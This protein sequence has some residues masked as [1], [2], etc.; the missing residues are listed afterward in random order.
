MTRYVLICFYFVLFCNVFGQ[1]NILGGKDIDIENVPWQVSIQKNSGTHF[2]GG[3]IISKEWILTAAHCLTQIRNP[4]D[5]KILIGTNDKTGEGG[6]YV[7]CDRI[8]IH[9]NYNETSFDNDI[10][11]LHL[12]K[13]INFSKSVDYIKLNTLTEFNNPKV[14]VLLTGW[15]VTNYPT[16]KLQQITIPIIS[17]KN[18]Q[19]I[20]PKYENLN[21]NMIA[22]FERG[23]GAAPGDSGG[24]AVATK[25]GINYLIGVSSWGY[26]PK[27]KNPTVYTKV[28]NYVDWIHSFV[29]PEP[30]RSPP[31]LI[32][33]SE[34]WGFCK[35]ATFTIVN[36]PEGAEVSWRF[37][38]GATIVEEKVP[39]ELVIDFGTKRRAIVEAEVRIAGETYNLRY[40]NT[41]NMHVRNEHVHLHIKEH[42]PNGEFVAEILLDERTPLTDV[43]AERFTILNTENC[44][45]RRVALN[46]YY[47]KVLRG[48]AKVSFSISAV[49]EPC[50]EDIATFALDYIEPSSLIATDESQIIS[51]LPKND[52][53]NCTTEELLQGEVY[54]YRWQGARRVFLDFKEMPKFIPMSD[55]E[56]YQ[57]INRNDNYSKIAE[58]Y[59]NGYFECVP[60]DK[61]LSYMY[62]LP[63]IDVQPGEIHYDSPRYVGFLD[64]GKAWVRFVTDCKASEWELI[65][66]SKIIHVTNGYFVSRDKGYEL[67]GVFRITPN[68]ASNNVYLS[69][70]NSEQGKSGFRSASSKGM[71]KNVETPYKIRIYNSAGILVRSLEGKGNSAQ[72]SVK[73]LPTGIYIVHFIQNGKTH[74]EKLIVE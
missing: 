3:S 60:F 51:T 24:P 33:S 66:F 16:N 38:R 34:L 27:D 63:H 4:S 19:Q 74:R 67:G 6:L 56:K 42:L 54:V 7:S 71:N 43:E 26:Y 64:W 20:N 57:S 10:A 40:E 32:C 65:D 39:N 36:F 28:S 41:N 58:K 15:G 55:E 11:L 47:I 5:I 31:E 46:R 22:L 17:K 23:K 70:F 1:Q 61:N 35:R 18:A 50:E 25:Y 44:S 53:A 9:P 12:S 68:P 73:G 8:I 59:P 49:P 14:D 69:V 62:P 72:F 13:P 48:N 29:P 52:I 2:C 37:T 30:L 45:V 21:N